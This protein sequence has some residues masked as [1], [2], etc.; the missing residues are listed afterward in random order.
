MLKNL[1]K[2][3]AALAPDELWFPTD[4]E[5]F[6]LRNSFEPDYDYHCDRIEEDELD[7]IQGSL[8]RCIDARKWLWTI[9]SSIDQEEIISFGSN[10]DL[11]GDEFSC[12]K[13]DS[14]LEALLTAYLTALAAQRPI[15]PGL[16]RHFKGS[17]VE[18]K[19]VASPT[20]S[21][22]PVNNCMGIYTLEDAPEQT[23][24][25]GDQGHFSTSYWDYK[26]RVF[27]SHGGRGWARTTE[28]FLGLVDAKHPEHEGLLRFV[29]VPDAG[30]I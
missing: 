12:N 30:S 19:A 18:V 23:V 26:N 28:S 21:G 8:Q 24:V 6:F 2:T 4:G 7:K 27:Y 14:P 10:L 17:V 5:K 25:L 20:D 29:E 16:W 15:T 1:L 3:W 22:I 13:K 11:G 9:F